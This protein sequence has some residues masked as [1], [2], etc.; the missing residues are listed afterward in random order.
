M[1]HCLRHLMVIKYIL[2]TLQRHKLY[3]AI[4]HDKST[5]F[6]VKSIC[7][8][9]FKPKVRLNN[10]NLSKQNCKQGLYFFLVNYIFT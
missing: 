4:P 9:I 2:N 6:L 10:F 1:E 5:T 8:I 3:I 7:S